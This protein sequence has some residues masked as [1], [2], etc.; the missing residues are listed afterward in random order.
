MF[1]LNIGWM[2]A[3]CHLTGQP[4]NPFWTH[5][6]P[7]SSSDLETLY[8]IQIGLFQ[9]FP[10]SHGTEKI[11]QVSPWEATLPILSQGSRNSGS[12][13]CALF[14]WLW[15]SL[16][17]Y[18]SFMTLSQIDLMDFFIHIPFGQILS[19]LWRSARQNSVASCRIR[20]ML[21]WGSKH[22]EATFFT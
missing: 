13:P 15:R 4:A 17:S 12:C 9:C 6:L 19:Q 5:Q 2:W 7:A 20:Q 10:L 3:C 14:I 16:C 22:F 21:T 1:I 11:L 8:S 18:F